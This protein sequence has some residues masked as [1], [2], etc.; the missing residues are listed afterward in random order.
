VALTVNAPPNQPPV[1][2][3]IGDS[4]VTAGESLAFTLSASDDDNDPL[5]FSVESLPS[6][7]ALEAISGEFSWT[8]SAAQAGNY[9][10]TFSV[11]D[12]QES[13]SA[14]AAITV[15]APPNQ[16]PVLAVIGDRA[17]AAGESL[18]FTLSASDDD[19][20]PLT[21]SVES[22]P[23]GA[24]LEAISGEFSW[25]PGAAQAGNYTLTFSVSDGQESDSATAAITVEAPPN[26][27]PVLSVVEPQAALPEALLTFTLSA[28]DGDGDE[29]VYSCSNLPA[30][31][32]LDA[33]SGAFTWTPTLSQVGVY[34]LDFVVDD[35][36]DTDGITVEIGVDEMTTALDESGNP[37][38]VI[39]GD[40]TGDAKTDLVVLDGETNEVLV[41]EGNGKGRF[42][43][44]RKDEISGRPITGKTKKNKNASTTELIVLME[45]S[46]VIGLS[47]SVEELAL[48]DS[49][50]YLVTA[51]PPTADFP[52]GENFAPTDLDIGD[53]DGDGLIDAVVTRLGTNDVAV[54]FRSLDMGFTEVYSIQTGLAPISVVLK[55]FDLDGFEDMAVAS[56]QGHGVSIYLGSPSGDFTYIEEIA[57]GNSPGHI[58]SDDFDLDGIP[59]L[60]IPDK[61][62]GTLMIC[63]GNGD[64]TFLTLHY[65]MVDYAPF[66]IEAGDLNNDQIIDLAVLSADDG[67]V[68]LLYGQGDGYF[69][70]G[71]RIKAGETPV[72]L[73]LE[74]FDGDAIPEVAVSDPGLQQ[75]VLMR[76]SQ[77]EAPPEEPETPPLPTT[78]PSAGGG[79]CFLDTLLK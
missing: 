36:T 67:Y 70:D 32:A 57:A 18:A 28:T 65:H 39:S 49:G 45:D 40:L 30:G 48:N 46:S 37:V 33:V 52:G 72:S 19:N 61:V 29:L 62:D 25:T 5:T 77:A 43:L 34:L 58:V 31:A 13:A 78:T 71:G 59:D 44:L 60:A 42:N 24:S 11:S 54:L 66:I 12:G 16:P 79:G 20:D 22:L 17:V 55:D 51:P 50:I 4:T 74:D 3:A 1:L 6:G 73:L 63:L 56:S 35:A 26:Q 7:A 14:T 21:F 47:R 2:A 8:P 23:S 76:T 64:G 27:P 9:T 10:L 69:T 41:Y 53:L 68:Y 15:E 75:V 38:D